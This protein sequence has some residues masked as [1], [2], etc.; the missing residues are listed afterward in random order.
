MAHK[1]GGSPI[2]S[3]KVYSGWTS[4]KATEQINGINDELSHSNAYT[5]YQ[6]SNNNIYDF[7]PDAM[8]NRPAIYI[9]TDEHESDDSFDSDDDDDYADPEVESTVP[10]KRS[11]S[12]GKTAI[13]SLKRSFIP[14]SKTKQ[15]SNS[16]HAPLIN[17]HGRA[18]SLGSIQHTKQPKADHLK[19]QHSDCSKGTITKSMKSKSRSNPT[20]NKI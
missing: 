12:F 4:S 7:P 16:L 5:M 9:D 11:A 1:V 13:N 3:H 2:S 10:V 8:Y 15:D 17:G 18:K 20:L 14:K 19:V 6:S